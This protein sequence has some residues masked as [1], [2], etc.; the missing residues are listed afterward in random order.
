VEKN[1]LEGLLYIVQSER[2][3]DISRAWEQLEKA[4]YEREL[5]LR[6]ELIRFDS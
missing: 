1:D 3:A 2:H 6:D 5:A 4:E